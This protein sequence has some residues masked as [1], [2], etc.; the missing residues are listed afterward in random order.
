VSKKSCTILL[1]AGS[2]AWCIAI[3][4]AP[5]WGAPA[6]YDFFSL[7]CHQNPDRSWHLFDRALPVC[8][9]CTSIYFGFAC[10]LWFGLPTS[11]RWLRISL[12][13][14][15]VEFIVARLL[16]DASITRSLSGLFLGATAAPF[17]RQGFEEMIVRTQWRLR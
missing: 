2:T 6:I 14:A 17:V 12:V 3:L 8:I 15:I 16:V 11:L 7:I 5:I 9:R 13:L 1:L 4:A 10:A